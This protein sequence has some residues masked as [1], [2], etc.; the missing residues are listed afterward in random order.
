M[1]QQVQAGAAPEDERFAEATAL[2]ERAVGANPYHWTYRR[3]LA[4][5]YALSGEL[6]DAED[7]YRAAVRLAPKVASYGEYHWELGTFLMSQGEQDGGLESLRA[8]LALDPDLSERALAL[9]TALNFDRSQV[10]AAFPSEGR[11]RQRLERL[12]ERRRRQSANAERR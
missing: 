6:V 2:A 11:A 7:Q 3:E 4:R 8:A 9:F 12:L 5:L 1:R 10:E